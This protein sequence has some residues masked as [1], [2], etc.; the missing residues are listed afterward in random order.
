M[1]QYSTSKI[2][3]DLILGD[4]HHNQK[5]DMNDILYSIYFLSEWGSAPHENDE[6]A[7]RKEPGRTHALL[8]IINHPLPSTLLLI[9]IEVGLYQKTAVNVGG[10]DDFS[11]GLGRRE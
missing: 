2:T 11:R 7:K 6:F 3:F 1:D 4:W 5:M 8:K 10:D 9:M